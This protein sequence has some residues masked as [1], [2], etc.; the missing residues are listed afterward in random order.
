M[1]STHMLVS[2]HHQELSVTAPEAF[3]SLC[4]SESSKLRNQNHSY[5]EQHTSNK[6]ART[7]QEGEGAQPALSSKT[8]FFISSAAGLL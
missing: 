2:N 1:H 8:L 7:R 6:A 3:L 5:P 4:T